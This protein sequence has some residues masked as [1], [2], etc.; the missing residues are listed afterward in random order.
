MDVHMQK[1]VRYTWYYDFINFKQV[2]F[3]IGRL[4]FK[5]VFKYVNLTFE[6]CFTVH[7]YVYGYTSC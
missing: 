5:E 2:F 7:I 3:C 1:E 6:Q 4:N